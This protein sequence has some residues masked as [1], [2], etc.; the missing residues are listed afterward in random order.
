MILVLYNYIFGVKML[1]E[2]R[3]LGEK[4]TDRFPNI[5][6]GGCCV[7][8]VLI[9]RQLDKHVPVRIRACNWGA[10]KHNVDEIR[11]NVQPNTASE[12]EKNGVTLY[13]VIVEFDYK[14]KTYHYDSTKLS[15]AEDKF[16]RIPVYPGHFTIEEAESFADDQ[17]GWNHM[18]DRSDIPKIKRMINKFFKQNMLQRKVKRFIR[19]QMEQMELVY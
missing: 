13:H 18:F 9:G 17:Y 19:K 2:L 15:E 3:Q 5:N 11:K 14:G 16:Y 7:L 12:W 6:Q 10:K 8:A 1:K 4:I